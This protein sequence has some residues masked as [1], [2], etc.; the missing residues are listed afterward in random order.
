[1]TASE[2][3]WLVARLIERGEVECARVC[4]YDWNLDW[5]EV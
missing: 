1:M 2:K 5:E 4:A 3:K